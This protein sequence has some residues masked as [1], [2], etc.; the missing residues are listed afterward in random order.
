MFITG[1]Y[2]DK[3]GVEYLLE[4]VD[5]DSFDNLNPALCTQVYGICFYG[6]QM[7]IGYGG[8]K[9]NWGLIGGTIEKGET[10]EQTLKREIQEESNMEVLS[11]APIGYQKVTVKGE[12]SSIYQLRYACIIQ[13]YGP[14]VADPDGGSI[15]EIKLIDPANFKRYFDWGEIG[16]RIITRALELKNKLV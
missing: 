16:E 3:K 5:A 6:E 14:F 9:E 10:F 12:Q 8:Q 13:P 7:V 4:Y 15:Q 11:F 1:S 2:K